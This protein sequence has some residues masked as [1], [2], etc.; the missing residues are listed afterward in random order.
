MK[1]EVSKKDLHLGFQNPGLLPVFLTAGI[2]FEIRNL[3]DFMRY[4]HCTC[5]Q[6]LHTFKYNSIIYQRVVKF[7]RFDIRQ[8]ARVRVGEWP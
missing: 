1:R 3:Q 7:D 4:Y 8:W 2:V 5:I 6:T